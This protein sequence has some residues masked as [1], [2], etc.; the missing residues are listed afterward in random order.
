MYKRR[1]R[2]RQL[3]SCQD[4]SHRYKKRFCICT[5]WAVEASISLLI[6]GCTEYT[7]IP[8][9]SGSNNAPATACTLANTLENKHEDKNSM[10]HPGNSNVLKMFLEDTKP[11]LHI[12]KTGV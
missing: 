10:N 2:I 4:V 11:A 3:H 6:Q 8:F 12:Y 7:D 5:T 9:K 1:C